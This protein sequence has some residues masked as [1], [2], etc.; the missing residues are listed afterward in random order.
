MGKFLPT[1]LIEVLGPLLNFFPQPCLSNSSN[2]LLNISANHF[3]N[4]PS[5]SPN[6]SPTQIPKNDPVHP[7]FSSVRRR[8][9]PSKVVF[10]FFMMAAACSV[11]S[12]RFPLASPAISTTSSM[13]VVL[14][15]LDVAI[16]SCLCHCL[17][18]EWLSLM[19][20]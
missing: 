15:H 11:I 16:S 6:L 5:S 7:L 18:I 2:Q 3:L 8:K 14:P 12:R 13:R 10:S 1:Q 4:I 17:E 20:H 19:R 9:K